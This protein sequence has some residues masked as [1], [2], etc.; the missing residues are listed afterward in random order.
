MPDTDDR[1]EDCG[2]SPEGGISR[3]HMLEIL[4]TND[5]LLELLDS[6]DCE[7]TVA[8]LWGAFET[9]DLSNFDNPARDIEPWYGVMTKLVDI[10][11]S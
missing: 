7:G 10:L 3:D 2:W 6:P 9:L 8:K 5:K 4:H 1:L 11:N